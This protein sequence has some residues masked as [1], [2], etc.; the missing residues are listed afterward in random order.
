MAFLPAADYNAKSF[1]PV[2]AR[3][4][5]MKRVLSLALLFGAASAAPP[6]A[7]DGVIQP[8]LSDRIVAYQ[9]DV[10]L[11]PKEQLLDGKEALTWRNA[12]AVP[13]QTLWFHLYWNA[14]K[15]ERTTMI[16]EA[17]GRFRQEFDK[18][19]K[20]EW[21]YSD[22]T[23]IAVKGGADLKPTLKFQS[24]DDQ[25]PDDQTVFTV[26]L[27]E[28]VA[29]GASVTLD[30]AW[31]AHFPKVIA[32]AGY[33]QDFFMAG[34]WFPKI[35]VLEVPPTR[36]VT[37]PR[38]NCH[39]YHAFTEFYADFGSYDV[40][41]TAPKA[42]VVGATGEKTAQ[43]ENA[44][45]T[46]TRR[47]HQDDVHDFSWTAWP[48]YQEMEEMFDE[49]GL[50]KVRVTVLYSPESAAGRDQFMASAK[51]SLKH[52]GQWWFPYPY[53]HLT[54]VDVPSAAGEAGGMEYP[55]LITVTGSRHPLEPK[56]YGIWNV[57]AHEFGHQYWYGMLASNEFE[58]SWLD[59][60]MNSY[61]TGK[62]AM[63]EDVPLSLGMVMPRS[64]RRALA[65]GAGPFREDDLARTTAGMPRASP[66]VRV[67]YTFKDFG[68]Y[69]FNSYTR[70]QATLDMLER[71]IGPE[72]M[73]KVMR[74]YSNR[75]KFKH[76]RTEDFFAVVNEVAGKDYGWFFSEFFHGTERLDY[77]V[78]APSC[79]AVEPDN[80]AGWF[81][82]EKGVRRYQEGKNVFEAAKAE[83]EKAKEQ[84][85][86][87]DDARKKKPF[88]C[89]VMVERTWGAQVPVELRITLADDSVQER[90][91][92]GKERWKR[93]ELVGPKVKQVELDPH[94]KLFLEAD[95]ANDSW[96]EES[97]SRVS[98]RWS[99]LA[100]VFVQALGSLAS[101]FV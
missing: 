91:W 61:G 95:P 87:K 4:L 34:Q 98:T 84:K 51:A 8:P 83:A 81:E 72:A 82:D 57:T 11:D 63:A 58:E 32:R 27:P 25:N 15:N 35:G 22:V 50:P 18:P 19:K 5:R 13:Q 40:K 41:V 28:P 53:S 74:T 86:D 42:F 30:I 47:F 75:W 66:I 65:I 38:W 36:G 14:F 93:F 69:G 80:D 1:L 56:D 23:A 60:G 100:T 9:I 46:T 48:E 20:E 12:S 59:E 99:A 71:M 10:R 54:V 17:H 45:G 92:D 77:S 94:R 26:T 85:D 89:K 70:T 78:S 31:K 101:L 33:L 43:T 76:P 21:G 2:L 29:P 73:G 3:S 67:G 37:A 6:P 96:V 90:S 55:T 49:P 97:D 79:E 68:D 7:A 24:P 16:R 64:L 62:L 44:D 39:Q 88:R 52:Y